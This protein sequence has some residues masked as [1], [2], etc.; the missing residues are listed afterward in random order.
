MTLSRAPE[1]ETTPIAE[2]P[3]KKVLYRPVLPVTGELRVSST[4]STPPP[5]RFLPGT[6][7]QTDGYLLDHYLQVTSAQLA[8]R[9]EPQN[10]FIS[11]LVPVAYTDPA[12][13]QCILAL[14]GAQLYA[15]ID[16]YEH[17]ARS[18]YAVSLRSVKHNLLDWRKAGTTSLMA[19]LTATLLLGFFET[20]IGDK[21]GSF[22]YH[23]RASRTLLVEL[24]S[25]RYHEADHCLLDLLTEIY[26]FFAITTNLTLHADLSP[27]RDIPQDQFLSR[28]V[29]SS[30]NRGTDIYGVL[31]GSAH[32]LLALI[33]PIARS[34]RHLLSYPNDEN[35]TALLIEYE[36]QILSW[37][38][39]PS[40]CQQITRSAPLDSIDVYELAGRIYQ[41]VLLIF[42][43][44]MFHGPQAPTPSLDAQITVH[45]GLA[46]SFL[47][48]L[49]RDA[50][51]QTT[52]MWPMLIAGS[53][54]RD[55]AA[56]ARVLA[57]LESLPYTMLSVARMFEF[58][59]LLWKEMDEDPRAFGPYG[60]ELTMVKHKFNLCSG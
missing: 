50:F 60:I 39:P 41:Q 43:Y 32:E 28:E 23:L 14:S 5:L 56:R 21:S 46:F 34:A 26:A 20:V 49:P 9:V 12:V 4:C 57:G 53:C 55:P 1:P 19:L 10:A 25:N 33:N 8:G 37:R 54:L 58:L 52:L 2:L 24:R 44:T 38:K 35:R 27:N 30:L 31:F 7:R 45:V 18:H 36:H 40:I 3:S 13:F 47:G 15:K 16:E 6:R 48:I 22:Y 59:V 42:L 11:H 29:L 51:V 17:H